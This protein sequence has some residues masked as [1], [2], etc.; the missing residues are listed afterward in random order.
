MIRNIANDPPKNKPLFTPLILYRM[1]VVYQAVI[2]IPGPPSYLF[3]KS[4]ALGK[5]MFPP[6]N[7]ET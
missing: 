7:V 4:R 3:I 1:I 6:L 5:K 2:Y